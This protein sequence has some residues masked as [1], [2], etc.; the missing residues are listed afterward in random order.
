MPRV[1]LSEPLSCGRER[2]ARVA[3]HDE[4][5]RSTPG[6]RVEGDQIRPN[7]REIQETFFHALK[8]RVDTKGFPL[9]ENDRAS[10]WNS[11]LESK[12]KSADP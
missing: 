12:V 10:V 1:F 2:L 3:A 8:E 9:H 4:I 11:E 6:S 7:R 5:H